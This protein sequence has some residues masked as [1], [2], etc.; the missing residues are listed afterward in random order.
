MPKV[1]GKSHDTDCHH[2]EMLLWGQESPEM[3]I[4]GTDMNTT[5]RMTFS[6]YLTTLVTVMAKKMHAKMNGTS[7][8]TISQGRAI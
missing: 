6:R 2:H 7:N 3:N 5:M 8:A 1:E 4:S